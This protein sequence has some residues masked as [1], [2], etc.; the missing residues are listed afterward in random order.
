[1]RNLILA[2]GRTGT[3]ITAYIHR[4]RGPRARAEELRLGIPQAE[5]AQREAR[6]PKNILTACIYMTDTASIK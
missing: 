5:D 3:E 4:Y 6:G 2:T 1:M